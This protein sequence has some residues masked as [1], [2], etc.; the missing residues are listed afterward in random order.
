MQFALN[1]SGF[2]VESLDETYR[3]LADAGYDGAEPNLQVNGPLHSTEGRKQVASLTTDYDLDIPSISTTVHW[4]YP[5]TSAN[6]DRRNKGVDF[7]KTMIDAAAYLGCDTVL[8]VPGVL[9]SEP[10]YDEA[11]DIALESV[12]ELAIYGAQADV[13]VAIENVG[14]DFLL[15]PLEFRDF[16]D[17]AS[18][19]GPVGAYV[20]VGNALYYGQYPEHWLRILGDRVVK[21]HVKGFDEGGTTHPLRGNVDWPSIVN[22]LDDIGYDDWI[23]AEV[24]PYGFHPE[25]TP[26]HILESLTAVFQ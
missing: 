19:V 13:T 20:D 11:Y 8:I 22:S 26:K 24:P 5:L 6:R 25:L 12:R 1:Q 7:G 18:E 9:E 3:I 10:Q 15:S 14:N 4:E 2:P 16:I 21:V 17:A 23:T